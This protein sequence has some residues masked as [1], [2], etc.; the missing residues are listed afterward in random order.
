M[1]AAV[2]LNVFED[3]P[4]T[5]EMSGAGENRLYRIDNGLFFLSDKD[6]GGIVE[7]VPELLKS[8]SIIVF[9]LRCT[10]RSF[11]SIESANLEERYFVLVRFIGA[12]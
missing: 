12:V 8:P 3:V 11:A 5:Q 7:N 9:F 1:F 6:F 4:P 2:L 10:E